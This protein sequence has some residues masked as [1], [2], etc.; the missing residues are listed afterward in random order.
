M[1]VMY[2]FRRLFFRFFGGGEVSFTP[3]HDG[4]RCSGFFSYNVKKE[5][6]VYIFCPIESSALIRSTF[7]P[8][9]LAPRCFVWVNSFPLAEKVFN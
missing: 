4:F 3:S 6:F 1:K 2:L 9:N 7:L 5:S 8:V